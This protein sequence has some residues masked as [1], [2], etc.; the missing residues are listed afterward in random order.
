MITIT[1]VIIIYVFWKQRKERIKQE[2]LEKQKLEKWL[3]QKQRSEFLAKKKAKQL[4]ENELP[5]KI[6]Q[7]K[8]HR[9]RRK[10]HDYVV[11]DIETT[12][13][14]K[15]DDDI[16]QVAAIKFKN[17]KKVDSFNSFVH[18]QK[19]LSL[20]KEI[21]E[22]T[23][24][25]TEDLADAPKTKDVIDDFSAFIEDLPLI[26][27]NIN[28]FDIPFLVQKGFY[29]KDLDTIDTWKLSQKKGLDTPNLKLP[30][31][32]KYFK[33]DS[34]SH[35]ALSDCETNA[36]VYQKLREMENSY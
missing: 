14:D 12:G 22:L 23:N 24:I 3:K 7:P 1:I 15:Y 31:L 17:D 25:C 26:G 13:L 8:I 30:T 36:I 2:E 29:K 4:A 27:H 28:R 32:K 5:S 21:I 6:M 18:L 35:D 11:F 34:K 20:P 10:L 19:V 16:I 9:L 33:I